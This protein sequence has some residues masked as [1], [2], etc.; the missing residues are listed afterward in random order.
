MNNL[1]SDAESIAVKGSY[2]WIAD[3]GQTYTLNF[4][5]DEGGFQPQGTSFPLFQPNDSA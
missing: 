1:G 5:A 2:S 3:D 4:V